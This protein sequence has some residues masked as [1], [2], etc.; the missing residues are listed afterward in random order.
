[1]NTYIFYLTIIKENLHEERG[2]IE[3]AMSFNLFLNCVL[4]HQRTQK[5][6]NT[7]LPAY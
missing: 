4:H 5:K 6:R 7:D 3:Y 2:N 1:M